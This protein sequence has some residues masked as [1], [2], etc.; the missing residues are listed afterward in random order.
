MRDELANA[1]AGLFA[2]LPKDLPEPSRLSDDE[3]RQLEET[4]TLAIRLRAGVERDRIKREIEAVYDPEGPA[5]LALSLERLLAGLTVIGLDRKIAMQVVIQVAMNSTPRF[6]LKTY[7]ALTPEWQTTRQIA[8][9][10]GLPTSTAR[11]GLEDLVA[12]GLAHRKEKD[13]GADEWKRPNDRLSRKL[14]Q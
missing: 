2:G 4:V 6:R 5:R 12:Q 1:V 3:M 9:A 13:E 10:I 8:T 11:R 7:E 14:Q